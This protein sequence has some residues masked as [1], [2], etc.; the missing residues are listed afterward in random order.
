MIYI[1]WKI[2]GVRVVTTKKQF[3]ALITLIQSPGSYKDLLL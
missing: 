3:V 2:A 1:S